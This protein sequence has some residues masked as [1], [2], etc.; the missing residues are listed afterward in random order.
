MEY[1]VI[2]YRG[3]GGGSCP[4]VR[5]LDT[6]TGGEDVL[7]Q[8]Y[9]VPAEEAAALGVPEGEVL[10]RVPLGLLRDAVQT[11]RYEGRGD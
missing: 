8:G 6:A 9:S 3:C 4:T 10:V 7:V 11:A 1:T 5:Q 2:A